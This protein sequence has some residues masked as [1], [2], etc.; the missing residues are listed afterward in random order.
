MWIAFLPLKQI[1]HKITASI[2]KKWQC[3]V[4][5][6]NHSLENT[7]EYSEENPCFLIA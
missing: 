6:W 4:F 1:T 3:L 2:M 7:D 5:N